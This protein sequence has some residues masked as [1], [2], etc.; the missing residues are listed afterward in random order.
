M[1]KITLVFP[2]AYELKKFQKITQTFSTEVSF[3]RCEFTAVFTEAQI[4]LAV[5]EM[6]ARVKEDG[7][8]PRGE[9]NRPSH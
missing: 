8:Y 9:N 3:Y 1:Q 7:T 2:S 5:T 4:Q 6:K